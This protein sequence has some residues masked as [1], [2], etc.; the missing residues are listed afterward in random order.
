MAIRAAA[1]V[2][3]EANTGMELLCSL[4]LYGRPRLRI[5]KKRWRNEAPGLKTGQWVSFRQRF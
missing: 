1:S 3:R 5:I 4:R 2:V